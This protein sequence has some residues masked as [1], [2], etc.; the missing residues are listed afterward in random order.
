M[1]SGGLVG[2]PSAQEQAAGSVLTVSGALVRASRAIPY[3]STGRGTYLFTRHR[4]VS[5]VVR[6]AACVRASPLPRTTT[7]VCGGCEVA[8]SDPK[9]QTCRI[10]G[11]IGTEQ[12]NVVSSRTNKSRSRF[13]CHLKCCTFGV[14]GFGCFT[15]CSIGFDWWLTAARSAR[16]GVCNPQVT[17]FCRCV[18]MH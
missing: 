9:F 3:P 5:S 13:L 10:M 12:F 1:D 2:L 14:I 7:R 17:F 15:A 4:R 16:L 6:P 8:C 11:D 18:Q